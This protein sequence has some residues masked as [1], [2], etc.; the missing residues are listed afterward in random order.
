MKSR[1]K[2]LDDKSQYNDAGAFVNNANP[3]LQYYIT[4]AW[5][6]DSL[7][8][9]PNLFTVGEGD[10]FTATPPGERDVVDY[11]NVPLRSNTEYSIFVRYDIENEDL[12]GSLVSE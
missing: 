3:P 1:D 10:S 12:G 2:V 9:I 5:D 7:N 4:A 11:E 8:R 6:S